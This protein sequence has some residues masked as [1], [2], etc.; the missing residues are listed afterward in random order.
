MLVINPVNSFILK[1][2]KIIFICMTLYEFNALNIN[3]K[4]SYLWENGMHIDTYIDEIQRVNL[5]HLSNF[6]V[7]VSLDSGSNKIISINSFIRGYKLD[8][9]LLKIN[10]D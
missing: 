2:F 1:M 9:Y 8:K 4:A 6:Y 7:E 3:S 5:Y 10:I